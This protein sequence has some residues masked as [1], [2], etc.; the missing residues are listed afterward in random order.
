MLVFD[1]TD[2]FPLLPPGSFSHA[3][4]KAHAAL[5]DEWLGLRVDLV[6]R[7]VLANPRYLPTGSGHDTPQE[8]WRGL[9]SDSLQ[10]PYVELRA[11]L[12]LIAPAPGHT[13]VDLGSGLGR[14]AHVVGRQH[15]GVRFIG[16]EIVEERV[17]ESVRCLEP[18]GYP[19]VRI[20]QADLGAASF[21]P[22]SAEYYFVYDFGS[23]PAIEKTLADLRRIAQERSI[24]VVARGGR[25]RSIIARLHPWLCDVRTPRHYDN[26]SIYSS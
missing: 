7:A 3:E 14:L 8:Y 19:E 16:Y 6:E 23:R 10:T 13:L 5:V 22:L 2:P 18:F 21:I 17:R 24:T 11:L 4:A 9:P 25:S 15:P 20:E 1:P 26:Y 12:H